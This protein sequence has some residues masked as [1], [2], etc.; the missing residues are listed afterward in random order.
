MVRSPLPP[1]LLPFP[2]D[3]LSPELRQ[4]QLSQV[5]IH[6]VPPSANC[7]API[8]MAMELKVGGME[9]VDLQAGAHKQPAFLAINPAGTVPA[10]EDGSTKGGESNAILRYLAVKYG[11]KF[12]PVSSPPTC[13]KIDFALD[14]FVNSVYPAFTDVVYVGLGFKPAPSSGTQAEANKKFGEA[15]NTWLARHL[16]GKFGLGDQ[17]SLIEVKALPYFF[18][19]MQPVMK[20]K[21]GFM[22]SAKA[23]TYVDDIMKAMPESSKFLQEGDFSISKFC[24][25]LVKEGE[26]AA[27][28]TPE[29]PFSAGSPV[30]VGRPGQKGRVKVHAMPPSQNACGAVIMAMEAGA[31]AFELCDLMSGAH[32]KPEF[33][34]I[35]P[36]GQIPALEDGTVKGGESLAIIRY[37]AL[38]YAPS[39]YPQNNPGDCY[40]IDFAMDDFVNN[41]YKAH[42][43]VAYPVFGFSQ[44]PADKEAANKAL[45]HQDRSYF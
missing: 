35:H 42:V 3:M 11:A 14:D 5:K 10:L 44:P 30:K 4:T 9:Y 31:G 2:L 40:R 23:R 15:A 33:L 34:A 26:P 25:G 7:C 36:G 45:V 20:K 37:L 16:V 38:A 6:G 1:T 13:F 29:E 43:E 41:V 22:L 12:Y 24:A 27:P 8:V 28:L 39:F 32:K 17:I 21:L 18:A 19:A